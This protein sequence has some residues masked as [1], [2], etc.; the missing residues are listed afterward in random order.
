MKLL[1]IF[2]NLELSP[3]W[4]FKNWKIDHVNNGGYMFMSPIRSGSVQLLEQRFFVDVLLSD[5]Y[6]NDNAMQFNV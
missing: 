3:D 1:S 6:T 2:T 5:W 4:R